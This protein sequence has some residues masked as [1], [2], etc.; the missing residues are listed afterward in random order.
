[1]WVLDG[2]TGPVSQEQ[3]HAAL[4]TITFETVR[5]ISLKS[6]WQNKAGLLGQREANTVPNL[7][8]QSTIRDSLDRQ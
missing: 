6:N 4:D 2:K 1:M 5:G 7:N 3:F 8:Q